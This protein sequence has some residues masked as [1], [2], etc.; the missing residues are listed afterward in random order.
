[1]QVQRTGKVQQGPVHPDNQPKAMEEG[2]VRP[3]AGGHI[4]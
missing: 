3:T 2:H 1:M 4:A